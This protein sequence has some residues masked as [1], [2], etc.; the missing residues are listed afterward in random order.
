MLCIATFVQGCSHDLFNI[1][2][3]HPHPSRPHPA[4]PLPQISDHMAFGSDPGHGVPTV[5][6][7]AMGG[8]VEHMVQWDNDYRSHILLVMRSTHDHLAAGGASLVPELG[9]AD[10]GM[11]R[12]LDPAGALWHVA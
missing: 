8:G 3:T 6:A 7:R 12:P 4:H 2:L 10:A 1:A 11:R 9:G 5:H